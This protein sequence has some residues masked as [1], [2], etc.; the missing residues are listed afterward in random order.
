MKINKVISQEYLECARKYYDL[1]SK[2]F[3]K[4]NIKDMDAFKEIQSEILKASSIEELCLIRKKI[5]RVGM[6]S[7]KNLSVIEVFYH[8][9]IENMKN[10]R[11]TELQ[12]LKENQ[13]IDFLYQKSLT[14]KTSTLDL[15]KKNL[16][17]FFRFLD[18][19][20]S[21]DFDFSFRNL[22]FN[23][24]KPL[25]KFLAKPRFL[26]FIDYLQNTYFEKDMDKKNRLI[27]LIIAFTG[28]RGDEARKLKLSDLQITYDEFGESYYSIKI[29]GKG[30]KQR[31][32]GIKKHLIEKHLK[33]W[34]KCDLKKRKYNREYLFYN[35]EL[36]MR[37]SDTARLFLVKTLR[38]LKI[39]KEKE[40][41]GLHTLR[42]SFASFVYDNTKDIVLTQNLLGHSSIETTK[43]YVHRTTDFSK[44]ILNLF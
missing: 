23:K 5:H 29:N 38:K 18:K 7:L 6:T 36:G 1:K 17:E 19:K 3:S 4:Y 43:I 31:V 42:H 9:L 22:N 33:E 35:P 20:M 10:L 25:P 2:V 26:N 39:I 13:V 32:A 16:G 8:Y 14:H 44:Q 12:F 34:L 30:N 11:I 24:E 28:I 21:Y 41:M 37:G 15:Y 27:L 40:T